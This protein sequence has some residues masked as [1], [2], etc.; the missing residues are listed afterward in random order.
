MRHFKVVRVFRP[1]VG[2]GLPIHRQAGKCTKIKRLW[3][4]DIEH[5]SFITNAGV[6]KKRI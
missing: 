2:A 3:G 5:A 1:V 6:D 4:N